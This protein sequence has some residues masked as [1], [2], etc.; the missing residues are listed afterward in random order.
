[1]QLKICSDIATLDGFQ[2]TCFQIQ[3]MYLEQLQTP[4]LIFRSLTLSDKEPL[5]EFFTDQVATEFLFPGG[6]IEKFAS[7]WLK[8]QL[9]RYESTGCGLCAV[10]LRATGELVGQCGLLRQFVDGIPKWEVGYHFIRRFWGNGYA[11]E[12]AMACRDFCFE[13]EM[14]ET[15]ISLIHPDNA[16][17]EAV[18]RRNGMTFWKDTNFKGNPTRVFRIRR[19]DWEQSS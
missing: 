7:E 9:R 14:A 4:R 10:E 17:S 15:I 6:D 13:N 11:T 19:D 16:R 3:N 1:M 5:L 8:N 2:L 12:A 18:A